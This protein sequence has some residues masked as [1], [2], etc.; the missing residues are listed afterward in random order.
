MGKLGESA[1]R[2]Y[3]AIRNIRFVWENYPYDPGHVKYFDTIEE[4]QRH[5]RLSEVYDWAIVGIQ[6]GAIKVI[7]TKKGRKGKIRYPQER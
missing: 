4:A 5:A 3:A 6:F 7:E 1:D 2:Q